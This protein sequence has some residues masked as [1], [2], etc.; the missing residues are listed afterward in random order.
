MI[1]Y[2]S[3]DVHDTKLIWKHCEKHMSPLL[4]LSLMSGDAICKI[5]GSE[6]ITKNGTR[7]NATGIKYQHYH[8]IAHNGYAGKVAVNAK[9]QNKRKLRN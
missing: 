3:K 9:G 4:N 7:I 8:C 6:K 5:C 1:K 2:C